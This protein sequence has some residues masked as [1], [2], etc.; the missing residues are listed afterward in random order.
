MNSNQ[1]L[2]QL[3]AQY[4]YPDVTLVGFPFDHGCDLNGG[5]KGS[6][7]GP[8][9]FRVF[10][11]K[12][13]IHKNPEYQIDISNLKIKDNGNTPATY[14]QLLHTVHQENIE[15][16]LKIGELPFV[17]GGSNDQSYP[18]AMA[19]SNTRK[20]PKKCLVINIDAHL[21]VRPLIGNLPH[22]GSP[23]FQLLNNHSFRGKFIEFACQGSQCSQEHADF[24][25][26]KGGEIYWLDKLPSLS[27]SI[28][29]ETEN[30][31]NLFKHILQQYQDCDVFVSF[32]ID[33]IRYSDCPGTSCPSNIGLSSE[34]ALHI[35]FESGKHPNVK[36][37][38]ISE[39]NPIIENY[40]T[41]KLVVNMFYHFLMGLSI[42]NKNMSF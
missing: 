24:V 30:K 14:Y 25:I 32:D 7:F 21:D 27:D 37:V 15:N 17:I 29:I 4:E 41:P 12:F 39:M 28:V 34:E 1:N 31:V 3:I 33:A 36:L 38:D 35:M 18:N 19:F 26:N 10:L 40:I 11:S 2:N 22:S 5:R 23:F 16:L 42:R 6:R 20:N 13:G 8:E 9:Y